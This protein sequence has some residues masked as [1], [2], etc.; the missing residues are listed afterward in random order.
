MPDESA[1]AG[2]E[3]SGAT[4]PAVVQDT[5]AA[6]AP[7]Q[8]TGAKSFDE[9]Y[10]SE[11]RE[12]AAGYRKQLRD[13]QAAI[14]ELQAQAGAGAQLSEKLA[15]LEAQLAAAAAQA[16]A[17]QK[18]AQL[19]RLAVK[20]GV[21]PDVAAL[22]DLSKVD[23]ADEEGTLKTLGKLRAAGS[24]TQARPGTIGNTGM[25]DDELRARYGLGQS[26]ARGKSPMFGG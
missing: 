24:G 9:K 15:G 4:P 26:G 17:A 22:I 3:P 16:E 11:L 1:P 14:K 20:A 12:E 25:T 18:Q 8:E 7:V 5:P 23:L 13:A 2:Q 10:V 19:T 21:D 6:P